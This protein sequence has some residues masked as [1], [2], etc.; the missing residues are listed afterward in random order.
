[1][2]RPRRPERAGTERAERRC[3]RL[4]PTGML[5][6]SAPVGLLPPNSDP[7]G[8]ERAVH[9]DHFEETIG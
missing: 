8:D 7:C 3:G 1:M 6:L 4:C 9:P 2:W 5:P